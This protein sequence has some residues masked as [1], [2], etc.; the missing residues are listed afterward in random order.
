MA[1]VNTIGL[2]AQVAD[3]SVAALVLE[4]LVREAGIRMAFGIS[5]GPILPFFSGLADAGMRYVQ[6]ASEREA[7]YMARGHYLLRQQPAVVLATTGA[8][9]DVLEPAVGGR[10]SREP[11]LLLT[12]VTPVELAGLGC[13]Q[14]V[15]P[16][17]AFHAAKIPGKAVLHADNVLYSV[18]EALQAVLWHRTPFVLAFPKEVL[19]AHRPARTRDAGSFLLD[20]AGVVDRTGL[21]VFARTL[22]RAERPLLV[23]GRE[24]VLTEQDQARV[25]RVAER[26][27]IPVATTQRGRG[28]VSEAGCEWAVGA[29]GSGS[30]PV[31]QFLAFDQ[32]SPVDSLFVV[33]SQLRQ[34]VT[35]SFRDLADGGEG[36]NI[37]ADDPH[38]LAKYPVNHG[39]VARDPTAALRVLLELCEAA[40][41]QGS[42]GWTPAELARLRTRL[43]ESHDP[44]TSRIATFLR[45]LSAVLGPRVMWFVGSG[46]HNLHFSEHVRIGTP[47]GYNYE[48]FGMM[49]ADLPCAMGYAAAQ[50]M[51]GAAD[52]TDGDAR[53]TSLPGRA[54]RNLVAVVTG[55]GCLERSLGSLVTLAANRLPVFILVLN[56]GGAGQVRWVH[57]HLHPGRPDI[58]DVPF[59]D[60]V[61]IAGGAGIHAARAE[62]PDALVEMW[63]Q[64]RADPRPTLCEVVL[65]RDEHAH[66]AM[67]VRR[68]IT[69]PEA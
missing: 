9:L 54:Q 40:E 17:G 55:D 4:T 8:H 5:G 15:D 69:L 3:D 10:E 26:F 65:S 42:S 27:R 28:A 31:A 63:R 38:V 49:G 64:F 14:E 53:F 47:R 33:G 29:I 66:R 51:D 60:F 20:P 34:L 59:A 44:P 22:L 52:V 45:A 41:E 21:E 32:K 23:L 61:A 35:N 36:L 6:A 57:E 19:M 18:R 43:G 39:L 1:S 46:E 25:C 37:I 12:A 50:A 24:S 11:F 16:I 13:L 7:A 2:P 30:S 68:R 58:Y 67:S 56:N 62:T 48:S